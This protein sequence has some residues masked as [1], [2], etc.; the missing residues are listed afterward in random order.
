MAA[1]GGVG[2]QGRYREDLGRSGALGGKSGVG[3]LA[4]DAA[5]GEAGDAARGGSRHPK[6]STSDAAVKDCNDGKRAI[7]CPKKKE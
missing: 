3:G 5:R 2:S 1:G 7:A 6:Q 4:G